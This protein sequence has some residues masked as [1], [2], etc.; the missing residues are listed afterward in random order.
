MN[1]HKPGPKVLSP[2]T[3]YEPLVSWTETPSGRFKHR[4]TGTGFVCILAPWLLVAR[5]Q[6]QF[7]LFEFCI[8][9]AAWGASTGAMVS[10]MAPRDTLGLILV[11]QYAV[12]HSH[13]YTF[14]SGIYA[15][16]WNRGM[17]QELRKFRIPAAIALQL[18]PLLFWCTMSILVRWKP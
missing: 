16:S 15:F 3:N 2:F 6:V 8:F 11:T 12:F 9:I 17:L 18:L 7:S 1:D 13:C 14:V 4:L 5:S 10:T